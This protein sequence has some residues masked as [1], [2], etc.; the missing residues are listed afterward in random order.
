[1]FQAQ[2][3]DQVKEKLMTGKLTESEQPTEHAHG[4]DGVTVQ[5][6][7]KRQQ[8]E[9]EESEEEEEQPPPCKRAIISLLEEFS[10][11]EEDL[12]R[13]ISSNGT[14]P[15]QHQTDRELQMYQEMPPTVTSDHP[16]AWWW[17]NRTTYPLLSEVAFSY[18][19]VQA[20]STPSERVF[21]TAGETVCLE[22]ARIP[23]EKA[24]MRIFLKKNC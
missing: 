20:S 2:S 13:K 4:E 17:N 24:D 18:L 19:C 15:I 6:E 7:E 14:T 12:K 5:S 16:A 10:A 8:R 1:M 9:I 3:G 11:A 21:S 22:R 23:P